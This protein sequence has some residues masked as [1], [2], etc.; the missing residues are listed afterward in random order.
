MIVDRLELVDFRNYAGRDVRADRGNNGGGRRQRSGQDE[1]RR[2][3]RLPGHV[4]EL[5]WG[6][7]RGTRARRRPRAIVRADL[8]D[9]GA[10]FADRGRDPGGRAWAGAGEPSATGPDTR[11]ARRGQGDG[12]L[13]GRPRPG[14]RRADRSPRLP[15]R[16]AG[17]AGGEVRRR[18]AGTRPHR[19]PAQHAA[20]PG[21]RSPRRRRGDHAR[22]VGRQVRRRRASGSVTPGRR[23]SSGWRPYVAAAYEQ[24][25]GAR[26]R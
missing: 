22:R 2:S 23:S 9:G 26:R 1:P 6:T 16:H 4:V 14:E 11:P 18:T 3:D 17:D 5:P 21:R 25:A 13:P 10:F 7:E 12:V 8:R 20:A 19:A 15:R 24:L